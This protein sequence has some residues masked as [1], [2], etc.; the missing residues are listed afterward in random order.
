MGTAI[1]TRR[2]T[3]P[4]IRSAIKKR[5]KHQ[6]YVCVFYSNKNSRRFYL[7]GLV[8]F[9]H[10]VLAEG[11][12][13]IVSLGYDEREVFAS[14]AGEVRK[15]ILDAEVTFR[16]GRTEWWEFKRARAAGPHRE[17]Y[18]VEQLL[19]QAQGAS[20]RGIKYRVLT[21]EDL[22]GKEILFDNWL[23]LSGIIRRAHAYPA[24]LERSV[25]LQRLA[26]H[27]SFTVQSVLDEEGCDP[28]LMFAVVGLGLASGELVADL[29]S[30]LITGHTI[31][32]RAHG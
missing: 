26:R 3:K 24:H 27:D 30:E 5:G 11:D 12:P 15:T 2:F 31:V 17:G 10:V 23:V 21:E 8:A 4:S 7:T 28:A 13:D 18:A 1:E 16:D 22:R 6:S 19:A 9:M 25:L 20:E 32:R 29:A 14:I